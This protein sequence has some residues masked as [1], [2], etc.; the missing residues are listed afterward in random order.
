[1]MMVENC[2]EQ[3][4]P[5]KWSPRLKEDVIVG[6]HIKEVRFGTL[7]IYQSFLQKTKCATERA[8]SALKCETNVRYTENDSDR[9]AMD[10]YY[11]SHYTKVNYLT[12]RNF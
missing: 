10:I 1:M 6:A 7:K 2:Q 3:Y 11:P 8:R 5:S 9:T 12:V 4:S